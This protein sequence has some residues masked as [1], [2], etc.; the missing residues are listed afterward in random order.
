VNVRAAFAGA[1]LAL[2]AGCATMPEPAAPGDWNGRRAELQALD[3][4]TLNGRVAVAAG[5]E[6]FSGGLTWRQSGTRA[7]VELRG[8]VG[9]TALA[10]RV[11]GSGFSV[12]DQHGEVFDGARAREIVALHVGSDL[13]ITEL[14]Y[15]L[16]GAPAPDAPH[17]ETLGGDARLATL[18][19]AGWQVRYDRYRAAG[20]LALPARL[21]ITKGALRL[22]VAV[23]DWRL[24]P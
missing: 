16:V 24:A 5:D 14:R 21:D 17:R 8:P 11:D 7:E 22:R 12:T 13:P 15:W 10:I 23:L 3:G 18:D 4:W 20:R 2:A 19:Q 1:M 9:G 6:G